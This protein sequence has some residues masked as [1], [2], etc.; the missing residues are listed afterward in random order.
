MWLIPNIIIVAVFTVGGCLPGNAHFFRT[1]ADPGRGFGAVNFMEP[2]Q[3][4][5]LQEGTWGG[6]GILMNVTADSASVELDCADGEIT[7]KILMDKN[8]NFSAAG[9]FKRQHPG[10]VRP[11]EPPP[12]AARFTGKAS[13]N[14]MSLR[15]TLTAD[16]SVFGEYTLEQGRNGRIVRCK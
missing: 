11:N 10:P 2:Q 12:A 16:G 5:P 14:K 8:G 6:T 1:I 15:I 3:R 7:E 9:N 13:G 4:R